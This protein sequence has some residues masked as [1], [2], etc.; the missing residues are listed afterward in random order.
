MFFILLLF[1]NYSNESHT[2]QLRFASFRWCGIRPEWFFIAVPSSITLRSIS[3]MRHSPS[4]HYFESHT[5]QLRF[6]SFRWCGIRRIKIREQ[7]FLGIQVFLS[8]S[9]L[10]FICDSLLT[11]KK[12]TTPGNL[13]SET[14]PASAPPGSRTL[15]TL[16][17]IQVLYQMS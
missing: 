11:H 16:I 10:L 1:L 17:K 5:A 7:T 3:L 6:A 4:S 2:A 13:M 15:H 8:K 9:A 12:S 14:V